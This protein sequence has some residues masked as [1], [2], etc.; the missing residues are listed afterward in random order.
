M[1]ALILL[2]GLGTRLRPF[3]LEKPKPLLPV[4]NKPFFSYQ[5]AQLKKHGVRFDAPV[6]ELPLA[7]ATENAKKADVALVLGSSMTVSPFCELP[8]LAKQSFLCTLQD[9]NYGEMSKSMMA[10][11]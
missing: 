3:T 11:C 9:T 5:I 4:L 6:P 2:G 7:R 8:I 10:D 1:K